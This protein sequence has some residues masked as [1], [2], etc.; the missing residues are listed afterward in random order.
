M[1][2][3]LS[4]PQK[5]YDDMVAHLSRDQEEFAKLLRDSASIADNKSIELIGFEFEKQSTC[6]LAAVG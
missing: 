2:S 6:N 3:L 5:F 4:E 1:T